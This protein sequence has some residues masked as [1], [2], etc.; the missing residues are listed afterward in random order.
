MLFAIVDEKNAW[1]EANLKE[2]ELT[3]IKVSQSA[4]FT[5]DAYPNNSWNSKV[6]SIS[7]ATGAEFSIL[8]PQNSSGNWVKVVQRVPVRIAIGKEVIRENVKNTIKKDLRV[9][10]SVSVTIDTKYERDIPFI[11]KP[12]TYLFKLF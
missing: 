5:P 9:G 6:E 7:P 11:I 2:T 8:P 4:V 12:F 1:L 10:M 3:N